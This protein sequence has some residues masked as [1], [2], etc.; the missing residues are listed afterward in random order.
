MASTRS[1]HFLRRV[2][3]RLLLT[4]VAS[5]LG[6]SAL[7]AKDLPVV[8][9]V[10]EINPGDE[11]SD[12]A[13]FVVLD[14]V[15]YFRANDGAHGFELWRTDGTEAGTDLVLDLNP[16]P[17]NGFP[18]SLTA[19]NGSLY[20]N[21]FDSPDFVGSKVWKSDG[22]A[23]GTTLLADTYPGLEGGGTFGPPLPG[24]FTALGASTVLFS[25]L[26]PQG[27][28]EPWKTDGTAAGTSRILDLHPGDEWSIP[29]EFTP[30]GGFACFGADDSVV[31]HRDGTAT[32]N[33]ELFRTDGSA[34]GT[35]RVKDIYPGAEP[36]TPT[37]FIRYRKRVYFR[38]DDGVHGTELWQTD[39]T[40]AGTSLVLDLNPGPA[41]SG[42]QYPIRAYF[43]PTGTQTPAAE[44][45]RGTLVFLADDGTHGLELF[46]SD[47]TAEGT[48]LIKDI[49]P[50]GD[51]VPLG[52][53]QFRGRVYFSAD[54]GV[55]GSEPWVT[56]GTETGTKLLAD[57]NP[58]LL[59][60]S[61]QDFTVVGSHL[62][63]VA[64]VPDDEHFTVR[65]QLWE[66][67]G[68]TEGTQLV[69]EEPG[70]DFG[71]GINN[72]TVFG[73]TLLFTAPNAVDDGGFSTDVEL[74]AIGPNAETEL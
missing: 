52:A 32:Y 50:Q 29:I 51:S 17:L 68:T 6:F 42:P 45:P 9:L 43:R 36:S 48:R 14:G 12:P 35:Y 8:R 25:A 53:T 10:K 2:S 59:R 38:A 72:L 66:T 41:G 22:T 54:D 37:D 46:R 7:A 65:T 30:L 3:T 73:R 24:N 11:G 21:G 15:A 56:D 5:S 34:T 20:F 26:D 44:E 62:F 19:L 58:G 74:F 31:Y 28:L 63:F 18:D 69:Y 4:A 23:A 61:P 60:S 64:I 16:G 13:A 1:I 27:G 67:D 40:E 71:Y 47:G 49:N 57:L 33:R 55:H 70:N 39:G